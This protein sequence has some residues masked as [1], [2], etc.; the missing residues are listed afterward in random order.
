[1]SVVLAS[2]FY[3][4]YKWSAELSLGSSDR[5]DGTAG[6]IFLQLVQ[7]RPFACPEIV[8]YRDSSLVANR[9]AKGFAQYIRLHRAELRWLL[10]W[11]GR[12]GQ[13]IALRSGLP[14]LPPRWGWV[15]SK[16]MFGTV[17]LQSQPSWFM[18]ETKD[19]VSYIESCAWAVD[20][21]L[22]QHGYARELRPLLS[23][24]EDPR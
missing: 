22:T 1:M 16:D 11:N 20:S 8:G 19:W 5:G 10:D 14:W 2:R 7:R 12:T 6:R 15:L 18:D 17:G 24:N 3:D 4:P 23:Q 13:E 21:A 9:S